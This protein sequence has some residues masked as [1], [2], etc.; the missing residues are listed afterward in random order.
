[1]PV[2]DIRV[3]GPVPDGLAEHSGDDTPGRAFEELPGKTA[4]DAVTH[5]EEFTNAEMVH[6]PQL[7]VGEGVPR[8]AG[9][10]RAAGLAAVRVAL[11]HRDA[12]EVVFEDLHRV[13]HCGRPIADPRVQAPAG[14][15]QQRKTGANFLVADANVAFF[16]ERH[17]NSSLPNVV[18]RMR[19]SLSTACALRD[20]KPNPQNFPKLFDAQVSTLAGG[21]P[22]GLLP[23]GVVAI[24]FNCAAPR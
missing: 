23:T 11:V 12:A 15:D 16:V 20:V 17:G 1:M 3:F 13:E 10:D 7:V 19:A 8:V 4:A 6:Q 21:Q 18:T 2:H 9:R 14:G 5:I 22:Y 24:E